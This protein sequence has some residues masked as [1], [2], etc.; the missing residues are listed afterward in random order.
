M[1]EQRTLY[2]GRAL[3]ELFLLQLGLP[4]MLL[5]GPGTILNFILYNLE[6]EEE[7]RQSRI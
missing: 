4:E 2:T 1:G 7:Y 6:I 3:S 5:I